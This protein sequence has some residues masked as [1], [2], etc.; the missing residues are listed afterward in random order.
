M[1]APPIILCLRWNQEACI[2][3][4][5]KSDGQIIDLQQFVGS[6][7]MVYLL[8]CQFAQ[9]LHTLIVW[10]LSQTKCG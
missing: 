8:N 2:V 6:Y 5:L 1:N 10:S 4:S 9:L 3:Y 7:S